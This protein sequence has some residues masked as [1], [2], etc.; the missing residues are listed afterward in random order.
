MYICMYMGMYVSMYMDGWMRDPNRNYIHPT[1]NFT[2]ASVT[3][4]GLFGC[5]F[6][7]CVAVVNN[8]CIVQ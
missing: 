3:G 2:T 1:I 8:T 4:Q 6:S 7:F 5:S